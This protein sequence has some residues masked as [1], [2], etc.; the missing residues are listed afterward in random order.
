MIP[1]AQALS[2]KTGESRMASLV[3]GIMLFTA[4]GASLGGTGIEALFFARFGVD[5]LPYMFLG[6]GVTSMIISFGTTAALGSVPRRALYLAIPL[7]L[8]LVLVLARLAL[9]TQANWLYPGLWLGKEILNSLTGIMIWGIAG[10]VCDARQAKRLFP[11]FNASRIL[12]QVIGGFLTGILVGAIGVENLLLIWAG[13]LLLAF[14]FSLRLLRDQPGLMA[15]GMSRQKP[16]PLMEEMQRGYQ[17][18]RRSRLMRWVSLAAVLFSIL[19]FSLALPFSRAATEQFVD[20]ERLAGFLGL[21]NGVSTAAAFLASLFLANRLFARFGVMI[22]ILVFPMIYFI[23]FASLAILPVFAII[24]GFRFL[25]MLWLSGIAD[26]AYQA[27]FNVIP[28][29]RRDQVRAFIGGVPEQAGTFLAGAI[30]IVGEQALAPQQLYLV[31]LLAAA[32]CTYAIFRARAGYNEA[33]VEALR[34]GNPHIFYEEEQPFGGFRQDAFAL[35][36]VLDGLDDRSAIVRRVSAEILGHLSLPE[37][38]EALIR[39]LSDLDPLV[40]ASCLRALGQAKATPALDKIIAALQDPIPEVRFEAVT[41]LPALIEDAARIADHAVPLLDDRDSLVS[42]RAAS[43]L[44]RLQYPFGRRGHDR[45]VIQK[46]K[47]FLRYTSVM[48]ESVDRQHAIIA[49]GDW[50]DAE[51]FQFLVN[52]LQDRGI[53]A[54]IRRVILTALARIHAGAALSYLVDGLGYDDPLIRKTA[55]DLL[56]QIGQPALEPVLTALQNPGQEDG[57]LLALQELPMPPEQPI[58]EYARRTVTRAVEYDSLRRGL[59]LGDRNEALAL[60]E[61]SLKRKTDQ[62]SRRVLRVIGL[63]GDRHAMELAINILD[64]R[65]SAHHAIVIEAIESLN[66]RRRTILQPLMRLW[67]EDSAASYQADWQRLL[68][69]PDPWIRECAQFAAHAPGEMN[70]ENIATLSMMERILFFK[71]VPLFANLSPADLKQVAAI[72]QEETFADGTDLMRQGE[73]GDVMFILV[74]GEVRILSTEGG[75]EV[76]IARRKAGDFVGEMAII[77]REPRSATLTAI[78]N[79]RT[80][81]LDQKSFEALLRDR[82]DVSL[83]V[84]QVLS[85]RLKEVSRKVHA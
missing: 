43:V 70:M 77:S 28:Q 15:R 58:E 61:D 78:G 9:L 38:E 4:M 1:L 34:A 30:L 27:M 76:E 79:V 24:V 46:A 7:V 2:I 62:Y 29:E 13:A 22:S 68:V 37:A 14:V 50:G 71:R 35:Q 12:G 83:A 49:M 54:V 72:A 44:L 40:R 52:E 81:C 74:T 75:K 3:I 45:S 5:Y 18:V 55:A 31:G 64:T 21:F 10:A 47:S 41:A 63:L 33:L 16:P 25:Q 65:N 39:G 32:L 11:L 20:E 60:L 51:A 84:I 82:P 17:Y 23:G 42:T 48:G 53:P 8:A 19:Y 67:E 26:P 59:A 80:L 69:D 57:A 85:A 36:A 66:I 73:V 56:A 6:L